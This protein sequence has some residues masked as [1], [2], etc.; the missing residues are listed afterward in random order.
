ML[1]V[2][3]NIS[4]LLLGISI[5]GCLYRILKGPSMADRITAL[6]TIGIQLIGS[7]AVLSMLLHTQAY[8]DIILLIG[9]LAFISTVAF[10]RFIERGVV[11]ENDD[12]L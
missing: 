8:V 2:I 9:I 7:V 3:L 6:D 1:Q 11:L 4:L 5:I 10:A 12:D